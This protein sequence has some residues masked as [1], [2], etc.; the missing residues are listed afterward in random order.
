MIPFSLLWLPFFY[1]FW[2]SISL[3]RSD[4]GAVW[5]LILG[6]AAEASHF[7]WGPLIE[8]QGF[9]VSRWTAGLVDIVALPAILPF[10]VCTLL[11]LLRVIPGAPGLTRFALL[12]LI[13]G[14]LIRAA[15]RTP[16]ESGSLLVLVPLLQTAVAVGI[17][18]FVDIILEGRPG[19][20]MIIAILIILALPLLA[21]A[22]YWAFF[23]Q[24]RTIGALLLVLSLIPL[25]I[26]TGR[27]YYNA[28]KKG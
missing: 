17:P 13:P 2:I 6:S 3:A 28:L 21:A 1:L 16:M 20:G 22:S 23:S 18:F 11:A 4:S 5:A 7:F 12:W 19:P 15:V 9:G 25:G 10:I 24:M 27:S 26:Q 14:A 8:P